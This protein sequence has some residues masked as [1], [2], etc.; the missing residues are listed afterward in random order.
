VRGAPSKRGARIEADQVC[1]SLDEPFALVEKLG[2]TE[3]MKRQARGVTVRCPWHDERTPSCSIT[4]GP[5]GTLR[6]HCFG[7][8]RGGDALHLVAA[9]RGLDVRRDF[10]RVLEEAA[11]IA[12]VRIDDLSEP[13]TR[14]PRRR[15]KGNPSTSQPPPPRPPPADEVADL[16]ARCAPVSDDPEL[17]HALTARAIDPAHVTDR[18]LARALSRS[19]RL[20][21]WARC[22]RRS[23]AELG[24]R[25][26]LPMFDAS[27]VLA[28]LH[29]RRLGD[30]QTPK[31]LSPAGFAIA[32]TVLADPL[33]RL[34][35]RGEE[36]G[37][38][39]DQRIIVA[40]GAPDFLT[41]AI[42]Y[43]DANDHAPAVLGVIAG[44]FT[45]TIGDRIPSG[46]TVVLRTHHDTAGER[47]AVA[48]G[49]TLGQR[50]NVLR[51]M[52][53]ERPAM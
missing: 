6:V 51:A 15:A 52:P 27:G 44:S 50:C 25:L 45:N 16:W 1:R 38:W 40:E 35:L 3:G 46:C 11:Q 13:F 14:R 39:R 48:I 26:I 2:L 21:D 24:H 43:G 32:G 42:H 34:V 47:Y 9:A 49:T 31:G 28:T 17:H 7:C 53:S 18:N 20:P 33:A 8:G 22:G 41:D 5:N 23:W 36:I 10:K 4:L 19:A 29:A 12:G 30:G 37:W